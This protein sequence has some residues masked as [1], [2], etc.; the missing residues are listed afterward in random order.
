MPGQSIARYRL[1]EPDIRSQRTELHKFGDNKGRILEQRAKERFGTTTD[2]RKG[3]FL[4]TDGMYMDLSQGRSWRQLDHYEVARSLYKDD[5]GNMTWPIV[6]SEGALSQFLRDTGVIRVHGGLE[7]VLVEIDTTHQPT[8]AQ[9]RTLR[10]TFRS[11]RERLGENCALAYDVYQTRDHTPTNVLADY[12]KRADMK[13][14][15]NL[16]ASVKK[17]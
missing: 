9:W 15:E 12:I 8:E 11:Y 3:G 14:F 1:V 7:S 10:A 2:I 6:G 13:D 5:E 4:L 17:L 16:E